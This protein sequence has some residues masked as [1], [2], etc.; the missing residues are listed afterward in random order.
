MQTNDFKA[1]GEILDATYDMIGVGAAKVISPTAKAMFFADLQHYDLEMVRCALAAHRQDPERGR[2]TPKTADVVYQ[3][4][5]RMPSMWL[6][7]DEAW[8]RMPKSEADS[9]MLTDEI[10]EAMAAATALLGMGD[11]VAARMA[12]KGAYDRLVEQAKINGRR[13]VYFPSFGSESSQ[14]PTMLAEAVRKGQIT[15]DRAIEVLPEAAPDI[16]AMVGPKNHPLIE[17]PASKENRQRL[18]AMLLTLNPP[19]IEP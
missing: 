13:P 15:L 3:I 5:R 19:R 12:F 9:A 18:A 1:F 11:K 2:F 8:A 16:V 7:A 17:A 4:E 6:S 10:A 14:R